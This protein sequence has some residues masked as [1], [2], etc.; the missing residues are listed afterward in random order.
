LADT[1]SIVPKQIKLL[2]DF[3]IP[4]LIKHQRKVQK[5]GIPATPPIFFSEFA[6]KLITRVLTETF[7]LAVT[8]T[9]TFT[10]SSSTQLHPFFT[11][12]RDLFIRRQHGMPTTTCQYN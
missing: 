10:S 1:K 9:F 2:A 11:P 7:S 5:A 4:V 3:R 6:Q 8:F 12:S